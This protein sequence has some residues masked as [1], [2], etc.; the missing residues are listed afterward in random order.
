MAPTNSATI[1]AGTRFQ[2]KLPRI[3]KANVTAGLRC[4]PDTAPMPQKTSP[5]IALPGSS[6]GDLGYLCRSRRPDFIAQSER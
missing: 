3:A 6:P 1:Y 2:G 5:A 4:A